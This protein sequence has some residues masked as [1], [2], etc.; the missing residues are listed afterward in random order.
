[1]RQ[2]DLALVQL[3]VLL[4]D[5]EGKVRLDERD[6]EEEV[7]GLVAVQKGESLLGGQVFRVLRGR[8]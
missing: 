7:R 4:L 5:R 1:M 3:V 6:S 2:T 8:P